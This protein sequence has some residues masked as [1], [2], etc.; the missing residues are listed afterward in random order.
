MFSDDGR[1]L[2]PSSSRSFCCNVFAPPCRE[3]CGS[4]VAALRCSKRGERLRMRVLV[5]CGL[6]NISYDFLDY[7][8]GILSHVRALTASTCSGKHSFIICTD[9]MLIVKVERKKWQNVIIGS[10]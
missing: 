9:R 8:E 7:A 3:L 4:C 1:L 6:Q 2:H 10:I 5:L